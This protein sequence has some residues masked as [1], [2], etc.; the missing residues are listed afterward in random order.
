MGFSKSEAILL[1]VRELGEYDRIV[2]FLSRRRGKLSGVAKSARRKYS[3]FRGQLQQLSR[4]EIGWHE[5]EGRE[6]V[7][8]TEVTLLGTMSRLQRDL[9]GIL[10][11]SYLADQVDAFAPENQVDDPLYR[12]FA[13]TLDALE[14]GVDRNLA[15]RYFEVWMLRLAGV[16]PASGACPECGER[17]HRPTLM[18]QGAVLICGDCA[19][20]AGASEVSLTGETESLLKAIGKSSLPRLAAGR[21]P[22][23]AALA[24]LE[25]VTAAIRRHFLERELN[26]YAVMKRTLAVS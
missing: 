5:R 12:L 24:Q 26:S 6:L 20:A 15:A 18:R 7:R 13:S 22:P 14:Q 1:S 23:A 8:I 17:M 11:G 10:L 9:E 21:P 25:A 2:V 4:C 3:R 16:F 19:R